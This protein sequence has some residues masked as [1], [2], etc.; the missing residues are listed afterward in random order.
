[1]FA[2]LRIESS[3]AI[4]KIGPDEHMRIHPFLSRSNSLFRGPPSDIGH[5]CTFPARV[6]LDLANARL[7]QS[8]PCSILRLI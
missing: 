7:H 2:R 8:I 6:G 4:D 3:L 1:M 5:V